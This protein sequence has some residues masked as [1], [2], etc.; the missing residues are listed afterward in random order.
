MTFLIRAEKPGVAI[1]TQFRFITRN[2][3]E[4]VIFYFCGNHGNYIK[5]SKFRTH[6]K[7]RV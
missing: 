6:A 3:F 2:I 4:A 5:Y 7:N 1:F